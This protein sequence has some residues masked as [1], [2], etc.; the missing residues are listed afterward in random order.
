VGLRKDGSNMIIYNDDDDVQ[1]FTTLAQFL[2]AFPVDPFSPCR[3]VAE[4]PEDLARMD[5]PA[6]ECPTSPMVEAVRRLVTV[7]D[8]LRQ[9]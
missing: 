1:N 9:M 2:A 3:L 8:L 5:L 7:D 4:D 6:P